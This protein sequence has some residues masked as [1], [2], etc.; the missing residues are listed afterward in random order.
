MSEHAMP[1][2]IN[3]HHF[4]RNSKFSITPPPSKYLTAVTF[5][6]FIKEAEKATNEQQA[7]HA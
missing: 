5:D 6:D 1:C 2:L 7:P 3:Y 4:V